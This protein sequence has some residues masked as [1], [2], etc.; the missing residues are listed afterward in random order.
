VSAPVPAAPDAC[1]LPPGITLDVLQPPDQSYALHHAVLCSDLEHRR[2]SSSEFERRMKLLER[3]TLPIPAAPA[4]TGAAR[5]VTWAATVRA[6][7][8][9]YTADSWSAN[10]ARGAPDVFP[11]HGDISESWAPLE[12][13]AGPEFI[14]VGYNAPRR[15]SGV[16]VLETFNPGAITDVQVITADGERRS[17]YHA[18]AAAM[19]DIAYRR[20]IDFACTDVPVVAVRVTLDTKA[21]PGWNEIDA[22]GVTP[23]GD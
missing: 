5:P 23:C 21:V 17:V 10:Q 13:D 18:A 1:A 9:Q 7:S 2:I 20:H 14:E 6:F 16:E 22:I 15:A 12:P 8:S 3:P 11:R 19:G 4:A